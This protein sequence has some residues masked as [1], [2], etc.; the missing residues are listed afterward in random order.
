MTLT[1]DRSPPQPRRL[2]LQPWWA[3]LCMLLLSAATL[4]RI[5]LTGMPWADSTQASALTAQTV[6]KLPCVSYAPFR[7]AGHTPFDA[8]LKISAA[9][10]E[11]DLRLLQP[12]TS[13]VRT[14]GL[15]HGL[16][17][18]PAVA[19][20]LG[21]RVVLGAWIGRDA[22]A[23][24]AQLDLALRLSR[25]YA[26]V[27]DLLVVGNEVLLRRELSPQALAALLQQARAASAVPVAY[28]DV[29]EFWLRHA[30]M[31]QAHV[32]VVAAHVLP[33]WE[34]DPVGVDQALAHVHTIA[35]EL[36]RRF[37]QPVFIAETGWPAQGRQRGPAVPGVV[38]QAQFVRGLLNG[39]A[40]PDQTWSFNLIEGFDQPWKRELEGAMG[41][42]WGLLDAQG[43][44]RWDWQ[45][46]V[47]ANTPQALERLS[48][49]AGLGA[50]LALV[51]IAF[52]AY[53]AGSGG[54]FNTQ[55]WAH[56]MALVLALA[57]QM[58]WIVWQ[59][60]NLVVWSR[61][62]WEWV[63]GGLFMVV[64][65][66]ATWALI[67]QLRSTLFFAR[68]SERRDLPVALWALLFMACLQ[69]SRLVMDG[70]YRPLPYE[71]WVVPVLMLWAWPPLMLRQAT[72]A[73]MRRSQWLMVVLLALLIPGLVWQEGLHN[74][75]ALLLS[76]C[77]TALVV[78]VGW[79]LRA[80]AQDLK[81]AMPS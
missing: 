73:W 81:G 16:D 1:V 66:W 50:L 29:W 2:N 56:R 46:P 57:N 22:T 47:S 10:I 8:Q 74:T 26:D 18:L 44:P 11:E 68:N 65:A 25:E 33:F 60:Q 3:L 31:L 75:Q 12:Y 35:A 17:Q 43:Q 24:Q 63:Q 61:Y 21:M 51:L 7:Q 13:C 30:D 77:W 70:R 14:Y 72:S 78:G 40:W 79:Q 80:Q 32:D 38:E 67:P 27:V 5:A 55:S 62:G 19:R 28:A 59:W 49:A 64:S 34:D 39:P 41:G 42:Y 9:M 4:A 52:Q 76:V 6:K 15:D 53:F 48:M 20:H 45:G 71:L 37:H 36:R 69:A 23:N 54:G 58:V